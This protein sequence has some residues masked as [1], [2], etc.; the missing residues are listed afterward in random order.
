M[1]ALVKYQNGPGN[2]A[3]MD[4]PEPT[5]GYGQVKI[6]VKAASICSSDQ[7][8]YHA[9]DMSA[10]LNVPVILGHEGSGEVVAVG[11]GVTHVKV[12][13]RVIAETTLELCHECEACLE[14]RYNNCNHRKGLGSSANG[15]F[16]EYVIA[17]GE[18]VHKIPDWLPFDDAAL[19]EPLTCS[20]QAL[21]E[22]TRIM[23]YHYVLVSGPG[24]IGLFA[25]QVAKT[26]GATVI[27]SGTRRGKPRL[28]LSQ[29]LGSDYIINTQDENLYERCMEITG[30]RGIDIAVE[31]SGVEAAIKDCIAVLKKAGE[32]VALGAIHSGKHVDFD[33]NSLFGRCIRINSSCSTSPSSWNK[34]L[35]LVE[36]KKINLGALVTHTMDLDDWEEG[37]TKVENRE[38]I[39]VVF[40]P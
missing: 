24:P 25:A 39:K 8:Y 33:Y 17:R 40:H 36:E 10:R 19:M 37:F 22:A 34:T 12:G 32:Y 30:G 9:P 7:M 20:V 16:A 23:P 2:M 28:E 26:C 18:S 14:G 4:I 6:R 15:F 31:C 27:V 35:R 1:K 38:A 29:K 21:L 13:D 11:E 3:I 5:P